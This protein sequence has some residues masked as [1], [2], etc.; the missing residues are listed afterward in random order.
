MERTCHELYK[1]ATS[2]IHPK[3]FKKTTKT[4]VS[5][6]QQNIQDDFWT[7]DLKTQATLNPDSTE[8]IIRNKNAA[9]PNPT[10]MSDWMQ[11][12]LL[13]VHV[14][15]LLSCL[16]ISVPAAS[17]D[18]NIGITENLPE[19]TE[20]GPARGN[21]LSGEH[22]YGG[23]ERR[24]K[25][26]ETEEENQGIETAELVF[27]ESG[28]EVRRIVWMSLVDPRS[29]RRALNTTIWTVRELKS[30]T[31]KGMISMDYIKKTLHDEERK[32]QRRRCQVCVNS[33]GVNSVKKRK[34]RGLMIDQISAVGFD[35]SLQVQRSTIERRK[36]LEKP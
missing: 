20:V 31:G 1:I 33:E 25:G 11:N 35:N 6:P 2:G 30:V 18:S 17:A 21:G 13:S 26:G 24:A 32:Q 29:W 3:D 36:F 5:N 23:G 28:V 7:V 10:A 27:G 22:K 4:L 14:A 8:E 9:N 15:T 16:A 12:A 19:G 34:G